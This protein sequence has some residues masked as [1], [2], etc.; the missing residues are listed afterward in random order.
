MKAIAVVVLVV[1]VMW[2]AFNR[3]RIFVRDPVASVYRNG[4]KQQ[5]VEVYLNFSNDILMQK[6]SD[7]PSPPTIL[8]HWDQ[9]PEIPVG[10][11]CMRWL[12]CLT[13]ADHSPVL[14]S[15]SDGKRDDIPLAQMNGRHIQY[16]DRSGAQIRVE[17]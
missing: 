8:Q 16:V 15:S 17:L 11:V 3:E 9:A 13:E 4:V 14:P 12:A 7:P 1:L 10:L 2:T 5:G 6:K